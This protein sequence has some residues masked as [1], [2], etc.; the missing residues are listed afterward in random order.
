M[1]VGNQM[2]ETRLKPLLAPELFDHVFG[3][4][5][6]IWT[7][8]SL[9]PKTGFKRHLIQKLIFPS[10]MGL[11]FFPVAHLENGLNGETCFW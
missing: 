10:S 8:A 1:G 3:F 6:G 11:G 5:K 4:G 9:L 2:Y 7:L